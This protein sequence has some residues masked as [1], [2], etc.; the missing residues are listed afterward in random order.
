MAWARLV[1]EQSSRPQQHFVASGSFRAAD[2]YFWRA[3]FWVRDSRDCSSSE[4]EYD[5][6]NVGCEQSGRSRSSK[7][8][9]DVYVC[10][11]LDVKIGFL[12]FVKNVTS[13]VQ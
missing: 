7:D 1:K 6:S 9:G 13:R 2:W 5:I 12:F 11:W 4:S 10:G 8:A 3:R